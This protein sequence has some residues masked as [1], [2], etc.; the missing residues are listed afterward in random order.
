[1]IELIDLETCDGC[2]VCLLVCPMD[3]I[4]VDEDGRYVIAYRDDCMS[5]FVCELE[6][7]RHSIRVEPDRTPRPSLLLPPR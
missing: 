5:C 3:V 6:C 4:R 2:G 1:M 7:R